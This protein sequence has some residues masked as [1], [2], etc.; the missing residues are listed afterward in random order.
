MP[1]DTRTLAELIRESINLNVANN[2]STLHK[3]KKIHYKAKKF[4][5]RQTGKQG[6]SLAQM[7]LSEGLNA[8]PYAGPFIA[9]VGSAFFSLCT[10]KVS[11]KL[12]KLQISYKLKIHKGDTW[13]E[14]KWYTKYIQDMDF[15]DVHRRRKKVSKSAESF[16]ENL[17]EL[18]RNKHNLHVK[19]FEEVFYKLAYYRK[20]THKFAKEATDLVI[21][22]RM[23][24]GYLE[25]DL[26]GYFQKME[27][28]LTSALRSH[29]DSLTE[30][31]L[32]TI[33]RAKGGKSANISLLPQHKGFFEETEDYGGP[34]VKRSYTK[35]GK[36]KSKLR[37]FF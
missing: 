37:K 19:Y 12:R 6:V 27:E 13:K 16:K 15:K 28:Q 3:L 25:E 17:E 10:N 22:G 29:L 8:I 34:V 32:I 26:D 33:D 24:E 21:L 36:V 14:I 7:G 18:K 30:D 31:D 2:R 4:I 11:E 23:I 9:P 1:V 35:S 5:K 20:Q